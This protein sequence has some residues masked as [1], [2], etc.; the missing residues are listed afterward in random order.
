MVRK[1]GLIRSFMQR[2]GVESLILTWK[3][4]GSAV[5]KSSGHHIRFSIK[6]LIGR[7]EVLWFEC[8]IFAF[9]NQMLF[10]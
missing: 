8:L 4:S 3:I 6:L 7:S 9:I 2:L 1:C 5:W 10:P